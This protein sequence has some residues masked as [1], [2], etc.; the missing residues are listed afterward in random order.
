MARIFDT[1]KIDK[2]LMAMLHCCGF[3]SVVLRSEECE[4]FVFYV[5]EMKVF[6]SLITTRTYAKLCWLEPALE[7]FSRGRGAA[8]SKL[9]DKA[10][11]TTPASVL[12]MSYLELL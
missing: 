7:C 4:N 6:K 11:T 12:R 8:S 1:F 10:N 3:F 9:Y 2:T 5:V